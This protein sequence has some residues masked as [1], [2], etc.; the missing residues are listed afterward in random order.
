MSVKFT[1]E[2]EL[3]CRGLARDKEKETPT[4]TAEIHWLVRTAVI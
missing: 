3:Y 1:V 4:S 2:V